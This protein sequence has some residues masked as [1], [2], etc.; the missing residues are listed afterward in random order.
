[1]IAAIFGGSG[2]LNYFANAL[3][4]R[5][6]PLVRSEEICSATGKLTSKN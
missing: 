4:E 3:G 2:I 6:L 5:R 1:M